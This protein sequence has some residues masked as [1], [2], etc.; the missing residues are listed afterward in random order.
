MR[1]SSILYEVQI[2]YIWD[3][4]AQKKRKESSAME[5]SKCYVRAPAE[6]DSK[7][8]APAPMSDG[9]WQRR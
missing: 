6:E 3:S 4:I 8:G 2:V 9:F 5:S 1:S 7:L